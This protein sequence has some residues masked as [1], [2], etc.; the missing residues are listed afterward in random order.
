MKKP[1][2]QT[3]Q[4]SK[5]GHLCPSFSTPHPPKASAEGVAALELIDNPQA[6]KRSRGRWGQKRPNWYTFWD[7][8]WPP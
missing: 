2:L 5:K 6:N 1:L 8:V 3:V 4:L 7:D